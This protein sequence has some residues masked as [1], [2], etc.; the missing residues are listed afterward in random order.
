MVEKEQGEEEKENGESEVWRC[1]EERR[2]QIIR[3]Q[4][5]A[6]SRDES[7]GG[8]EEIGGGEKR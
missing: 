3:E 2:E 8:A 1:R 4:R 7:Y 5:K 6:V